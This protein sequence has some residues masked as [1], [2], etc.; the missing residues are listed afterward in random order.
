[1]KHKHFS[2]ESQTALY[3]L[4]M[5]ETNAFFKAPGEINCLYPDNLS[6]P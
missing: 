3:T 6:G 2:Q 4:L 1:M 5:S